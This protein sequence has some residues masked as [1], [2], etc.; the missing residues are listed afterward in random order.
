MTRGRAEVVRRTHYPEV[1]GSSPTGRTKIFLK[2][3]LTE[4]LNSDIIL[5]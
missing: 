2:K 1:V 4:S 5:L 3:F